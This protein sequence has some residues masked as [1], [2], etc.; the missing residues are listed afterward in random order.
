[1]SNNFLLVVTVS[2]YICLVEQKKKASQF[3]IIFIRALCCLIPF[4]G[5]CRN[6]GQRL[7]Y[8]PL[9]T[10]ALQ[11]GEIL[12]LF[13]G[14]ERI[15]L[16]VQCV[17]KRGSCWA[18]ALEGLLESPLCCPGIHDSPAVHMG[19]EVGCSPDWVA[20]SSN[21]PELAG[22]VFKPLRESG[23]LSCKGVVE[24]LLLLHG[25]G[26]GEVSFNFMASSLSLLVLKKAMLK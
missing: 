9:E 23:A 3:R 1:M 6:K 26:R 21:L 13:R 14:K 24:N 22:K 17:A 11:A 7:I 20:W 18:A 19:L 10:L 5:S 25:C 2:T 12:V 15:D 4:A 16:S 8:F